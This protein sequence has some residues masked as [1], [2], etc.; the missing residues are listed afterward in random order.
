MSNI[1]IN[2]GYYTA[3]PTACGMTVSKNGHDQFAIECAIEVA[4]EGG[5]RTVHMTKFG[6]LEGEGL[7]YTMRDAETCGCDV[8]QDIRE[9]QVDPTKTIRVRV[10]IDGQYGAKLKSIFPLDGGGG[11]LIQKQAMAEDRKAAVASAVNQRLAALR[12]KAGQASGPKAKNGAA[13]KPAPQPQA[14][15][16]DGLPF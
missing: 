11:V 8:S 15:E 14:S 12:A 5:T 6:G 9:W 4:E 2:E 13:P 7:E 16:D 1:E 3:K 10:I